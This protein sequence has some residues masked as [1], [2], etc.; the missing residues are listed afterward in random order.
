MRRFSLAS[1]VA[2]AGLVATNASPAGA[3]V[4]IGATF[5]GATGTCP[6]GETGLQASSPGS[7]PEYAAPFDGVITSWSF[8]ATAVPPTVL[9]LKVGRPAGGNVFTIIGESP[10]KAPP[11]GVLST[12]NDVRI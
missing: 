1:L 3:A 10:P 11:G 8:H 6:Q 4:T 5:P 7:P 2:V 12:Y 9:K